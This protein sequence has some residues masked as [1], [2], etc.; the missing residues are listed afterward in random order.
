MSYLHEIQGNGLRPLSIR[1]ILDRRQETLV[2]WLSL[3]NDGSTKGKE[4]NLDGQQPP[5]PRVEAKRRGRVDW[6]GDL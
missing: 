5:M 4:P 2:N 3:R 6:S 1:E